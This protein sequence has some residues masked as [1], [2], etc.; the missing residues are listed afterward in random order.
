MPTIEEKFDIVEQS[1]Q[2]INMVLSELVPNMRLGFEDL[3]IE[4]DADDIKKHYFEIQSVRNDIMF[5][6]HISSISG[7]TW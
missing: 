3:G 5:V 4:A 7:S 6:P 1:I 2:S